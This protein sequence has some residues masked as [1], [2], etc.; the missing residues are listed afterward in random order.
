[1]TMTGV[2]HKSRRGVV[3]VGHIGYAAEGVVYCVLGT[4]P[5]SLRSVT[6][7]AS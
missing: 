1:M 7:A 4:L 5:S 2:G 3:Y 6:R